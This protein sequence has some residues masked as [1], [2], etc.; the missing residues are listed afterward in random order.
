MEKAGISVLLYS[1]WGWGDGDLD[2]VVEGHP[3]QFINRSLTEMLNQIR[4]S[5]REMKVALIVEPFTVTQAGLS[6]ELTSRESRMVLGY[7]WE[8]YYAKYQ[9]QMF[10][11]QGKPLVVSFDPMSLKNDGRYT[12]M[13]WTGRAFDEVVKKDWDWSFAPPQ[14]LSISKDGV[15]FFYP[16]FDEFYLVE[17]GATYITGEP[18]RIDPYLN[19]GF[20]D[21][22]WE[23]LLRLCRNVT[24]IVLYSW[25][26]YGEQA[27]IEPSNGGSAP[28][29]VEFL[30][31]T[32]T[33]YDEFKGCL[34][35]AL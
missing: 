2:G 14:S 31:K 26:I 7:V 27:H 32:R 3:D 23:D 30:D 17:D 34:S 11:W 13:K 28:V 25:N 9:G 15:V 29:G 24:M 6:G 33:Y 19:E 35:N 22:Q 5:G 16:R 18:R 10:E 4:D 21:R 8:N 12:L 20:Y 1:W